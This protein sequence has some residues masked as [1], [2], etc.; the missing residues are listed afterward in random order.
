[1]KL[2][3][4]DYVLSE[5]AAWVESG[6]FSIRI[7]HVD[8]AIYVDIYKNGH[9]GENPLSTAYANEDWTHEGDQNDCE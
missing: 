6:S 2:K 8:G 3:D 1:M 9:E 7:R 5:G 4:G